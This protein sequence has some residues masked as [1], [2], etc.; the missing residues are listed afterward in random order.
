[1]HYNGF[2]MNYNQFDI[3]KK[4]PGGLSGSKMKT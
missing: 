1:M 2:L 4:M 3:I